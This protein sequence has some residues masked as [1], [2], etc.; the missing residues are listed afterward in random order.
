ML[1]D[2]AVQRIAA[3]FD[4]STAVHM[5]TDPHNAHQRYATTYRT[6][7]GAQQVRDALNAR[8]IYEACYMLE[9][10]LQCGCRVRMRDSAYITPYST[11]HA[12]TC[13]LDHRART[14]GELL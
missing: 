1:L 4:V 8:Y 3:H 12:E 2:F 14:Q 10:T 7:T 5:V 9:I 6:W 11:Q 13:T